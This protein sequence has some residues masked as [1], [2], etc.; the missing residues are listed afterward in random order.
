MIGKSAQVPAGPAEHHPDLEEQARM[1]TVALEA[2]LVVGATVLLVSA[3]SFN[4]SAR[5][6]PVIVLSVTIAL[7]LI[8]VVTELVPGLRR[9]KA[10]L[11]VGLIE[12]P[13][14]LVEATHKAS[15]GSDGGA[16]RGFSEWVVIAWLVFLGVA[17]FL[18][19]YRIAAPVFVALFG[20]YARVPVRVWLLTA[21]ALALLGHFV[22]FGVF[23]LR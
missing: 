13:H 8:D 5:Q 11:E 17:M 10:A 2:V 23:N 9:R 3:M 15:E 18:I 14:E 21:I 7:L 16:R 19:G 4:D 6:F 12:A 20:L 1:G 22:L